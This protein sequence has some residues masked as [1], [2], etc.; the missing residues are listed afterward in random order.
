MMRFH[1][2]NLLAF[3]YRVSSAFL[4]PRGRRSEKRKDRK[5]NRERERERERA[6]ATPSY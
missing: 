1:E 5:R 6:R 4:F 3:V 2:M